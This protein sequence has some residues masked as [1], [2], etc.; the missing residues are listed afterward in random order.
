MCKDLY[1]GGWKVEAVTDTVT[2]K[3]SRVESFEGFEKMGVKEEQLYLG[4]I[5]SMDGRPDK[6]FQA[7]KN[8]G[9]GII[10][11]IMYI[12]KSVFFGNY[13]FEVAL[14]IRSSLFLSSILLNSEAWVN[15]SEKNIRSLEQTDEILLS[16]ILD[17]DSN[18]SNTV[19]YLELGVSPLRFEIMTRKFL[20]M[21]YILKQEKKQ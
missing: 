12:L 10:N 11:Q 20:F 18:T 5:V 2:G 14:V 17:C 7:R 4:D 19:K 15:Y 3:C 1:V 16:R 6:N 13:Q 8:K 21:Q 9:L